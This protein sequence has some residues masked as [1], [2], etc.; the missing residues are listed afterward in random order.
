[1]SYRRIL[2]IFVL[3]VA[4][5][6]LAAWVWPQQSGQ[7]GSAGTGSTSTSSTASDST[8]ATDTMRRQRSSGDPGAPP[9]RRQP[10]LFVSGNVV[11]DDG[12]PPPIGVVIERV[13]GGQVT[14]EA[15]MSPGGSFSFQVGANNPVFLEASDE[16]PAANWDPVRASSGL[17]AATS[18]GSS[19]RLEGCDLRAR[20]GGYRSNILILN[21]NQGSGNVDVGTLVL[22]PAARVRGTAV[23]ATALAAP[24]K[25]KKSVEQ[26][27]AA[28]K[29][30]DLKKAQVHLEAALAAYPGYAYAWCRLGQI[31]EISGHNENARNAFAK[32]LEADANYVEPYIELARMNAL[33]KKWQET[34][35]LTGRA[36]KLDPLD[37]PYGY[38]LDALSN[39]YLNQLDAAERSVRMLQRLDS[40][41]RYAE[42]FLLFAN[43][44]RRKHDG[45]GEAAQLIEY[46][47]YA[48]QAA[49][50]VQVR[51]RLQRLT[52][53]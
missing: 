36:L 22:Y 12:S 10:V 7:T 39:F 20:L 8:T 47:K 42:G 38:Y 33:E 3:A 52:G 16:R 46:L 37:F 31:H 34:A 11:L 35:D 43:I 28:L 24:K 23:S 17:F 40:R 5:H 26:A 44:Y 49:D 27:E 32:A 45:A 53:S 41:H 14:K 50:A 13:C 18:S 15:Y 6:G 2:P 1:M 19:I 51:A 4:I 9:M 21:V 48:P 25:A 29:K 30:K